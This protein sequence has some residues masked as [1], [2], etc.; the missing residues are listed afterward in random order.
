MGF[1]ESISRAFFNLTYNE[2][3]SKAYDEQ[4]E[5]A[6]GAVE[7][8]KKQIQG[9]RETREKI[10][11]AGE[12]SD[13]FSTNSLSRITEWEKWLE[14]NS[15]LAA[16]DYSKKSTEM[17]TQWESLVNV[18]KIV[19]EMSRVGPFIDLYLID[20]QATIP[21]EQKTELETLKADAEKYYNKITNKSPPDIIAKRDEFNKRFDDIQKKIPENFLDLKDIKE[22]FTS[23]SYSIKSLFQGIQEKQFNDYKNYVN[24][25][26]LA[27]ENTFSF[28]RLFSRSITYG[29]QGF[30]VFFPY[31][32]SIIFAMVIANDAI[33]RPAPY[34]IFYFLFMFILFNYSMVSGLWI[35][36]VLYYLYRAIK[37]VNWTNLFSLKPEGPRMDYLTAPVLFAFLPLYEAA[38]DEEVPWYYS[39]FKYDPN[40]YGGLAKKKAMAYEM[41]AA[42]LVGA[43]LDP[44]QFG[45]DEQSFNQV[46]CDLKSVLVNEP[47][48]S[49]ERVIESVRSVM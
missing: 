34:R 1:F 46:L 29:F 37:A 10:I 9:Y 17:K 23:P 7:D 19:L 24:E 20:K 31:L 18:N 2:Q 44:S 35:V 33:G 40:L 22:P 48:N 43:P 4:N 6:A 12:S 39:I 32:F 16:G 14:G 15:G 38:A 11:G 36:V 30:A 26:E 21:N 45:M 5:K 42:R 28:S 41:N 27:D 8:I 3:A 47:S 25:K 13:Y 49:F